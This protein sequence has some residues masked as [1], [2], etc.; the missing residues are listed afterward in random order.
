MRILK[1]PK[2]VKLALP[3]FQREALDVL[4]E[5][6]PQIQTDDDLLAQ[7]LSRGI[8][9]MLDDSRNANNSE[10]YPSGIERLKRRLD[11]MAMIADGHSRYL[12]SPPEKPPVPKTRAF[13]GYAAAPIDESLTKRLNAYLQDHPELT[14]EDAVVHLLEIGVAQAARSAFGKAVTRARQRILTGLAQFNG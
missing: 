7:V 8:L 9:S 3:D 12:D 11:D 6:Q 2:T 5:R 14:E 13:S 4:L 1:F 10:T